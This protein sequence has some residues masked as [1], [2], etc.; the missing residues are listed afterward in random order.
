[1]KPENIAVII[2]AVFVIV[3][4]YGCAK[5]FTLKDI[6]AFD[7]NPDYD[8]FCACCQARRADE[9]GERMEADLKALEEYQNGQQQHG[10]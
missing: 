6:R 1:M 9:E 5:M 3:L 4:S 7:S 10:R 8:P 2:G